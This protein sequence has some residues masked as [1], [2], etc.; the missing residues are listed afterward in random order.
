[1]R[2]RRLSI[3]NYENKYANIPRDYT[4][5]LSWM[6]DHYGINN[7]ISNQI[8]SARQ[9]FIDQTQYDKIVFTLWEEPLSTP[10]PKASIVNRRNMLNLTE[11]PSFIH[12]RS[13]GAAENHEWFNMYAKE[14]L[15][16]KINHIICTACSLVIRTYTLTPSKFNKTDIFLSEIG[17]IRPLLRPD[18]DNLSKTYLDMFSG[19]IIL[20]DMLVTDL[21][22]SKYYSI[23][24]RVEIELQW[25]NLLGN[26]YQY[27]SIIARKDFPDNV[28]I[29]YIGS[30]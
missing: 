5:R 11:S 19:N 10:R 21:N 12:I 23:L 8:I 29:S 17:L 14:R 2:D 30:I 28:T 6:Y 9:Q 1:M 26:K 13:E 22:I 16:D 20:E 25:A 27:N 3:I 24:P 4:E 7:N 15:M 18:V